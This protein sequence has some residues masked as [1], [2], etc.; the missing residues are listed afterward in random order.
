[1]G[2]PPESPSGETASFRPDVLRALNPALHQQALATA[3]LVNECLCLADIGSA[4]CAED[5]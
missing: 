5:N 1:M 2:K 4:R 3:K